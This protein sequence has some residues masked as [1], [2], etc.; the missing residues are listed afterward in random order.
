M[1]R[2]IAAVLLALP[3]GA[4]V[5]PEDGGRTRSP[6]DLPSLAA[7]Q[8]QPLLALADHLLG[9]YFASDV[10][11]QPTVCLAISDGREETALPPQDERAL[12]MR[13][14]RLSPMSRCVRSGLSLV[15]GETGGPALLFAVHSF[16]CAEA[17]RCTGFA[18]FSAGD[19]QSLSSLYRMTWAGGAWQFEQD[20]RLLGAQ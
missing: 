13:H 18:G 1:M 14:V 9:N 4:C 17:G 6:R 8:E 15:D 5:V 11:S 20:R 19:Q 10:V 2:T 3:L 7:Q 16:T 12:M